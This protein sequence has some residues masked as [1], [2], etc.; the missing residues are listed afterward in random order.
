MKKKIISVF[1]ATPP[2]LRP[3]VGLVMFALMVTTAIVWV[4]LFLGYLFYNTMM[5]D[6]KGGE[7]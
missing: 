4:P 5:R 1:L 7:G 2:W 6:L 3:V